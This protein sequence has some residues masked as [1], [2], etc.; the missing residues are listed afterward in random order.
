MRAL[1]LTC[2]LC[3]LAAAA[4]T[5]PANLLINGSFADVKDRKPVGWMI[6]AQGH[7]IY[8]DKEDHPRDVPQALKVEIRQAADAEGAVL[9]LVHNVP[10][11]TKLV[12][13]GAMMGSN[14]RLA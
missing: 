8:V 13:S 2:L 7:D 12:L 11:N 1:V 5:A 10:A 6:A 14:Q 4:D 9:Q 3:A